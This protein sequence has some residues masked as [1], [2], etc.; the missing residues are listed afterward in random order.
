MLHHPCIL[1]GPKQWGRNQKPKAT[2]RVTMMLLGCETNKQGEHPTF[3]GVYRDSTPKLPHG[4]QT[5]VVT[6]LQAWRTNI[7]ERGTASIARVA[8]PSGE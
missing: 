3:H 8:A 1:R 5:L 4:H 6:W 7:A 2:P